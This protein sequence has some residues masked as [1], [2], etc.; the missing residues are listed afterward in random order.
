MGNGIIPLL[1]GS[2]RVDQFI[3]EQALTV[4]DV[5]AAL[6]YYHDYRDEIDRQMKDEEVFVEEMKRQSPSLL[7][8]KLAAK[9]AQ[10]D[11]VSSR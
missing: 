11:S 2:G 6:A 1:L 7:Q 9:D 10:D 3:F 5:Y 4:A 8:R